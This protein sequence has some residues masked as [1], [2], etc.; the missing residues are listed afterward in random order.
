LAALLTVSA[1]LGLIL[2]K[3]WEPR[4]FDLLDFSE[5][6]PRLIPCETYPDRLRALL[7]YYVQDQGRFNL[8]PYGFIALKWSLF[9]WN[10]SLWYSARFLQML[11]IL[12]A[13]FALLRRL[14]TSALGAAFGASLY[15]STTSAMTA[16]TRLT[17]GEPLALMFMLAATGLACSY[18]ATTRWRATAI[19][20]GLLIAGAVLSKEMVVALAPLPWYIGCSLKP[21]GKLIPLQ[22]SPRNA[23]LTISIGI[24]LVLTLAPIAWVAAHARQEGF[25][26]QY[27]QDTPSLLWMAARWFGFILPAWPGRPLATVFAANVLF[28]VTLVH[29]WRIALSDRDSR[30]SRKR[31]LLLSLALPTIGALAYVPWP[32]ILPFYGFPFQVAESI[33]LAVAVT[34]VVQRFPRAQP[35]IIVICCCFL[36]GFSLQAY[37][38]ARQQFAREEINYQLAVG[39]PDFPAAASGFTGARVVFPESWRGPGPA[40]WRYS[41]AVTRRRVTTRMGNIHCDQL[42]QL[43][44]HGTRSLLISYS[45][46]CGTLKRPDRSYVGYF[47]YLEL[48]TFLLR[49]DSLRVDVAFPD[50]NR[51]Q[52]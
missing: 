36:L 46:E 16:W 22:P 1:A 48:P 12:A 31:L 41:Q 39:L 30:Q 3:P 43:E 24:C 45:N 8:L 6:L 34:A 7:T 25:A 49:K 9:G 18:Q 35:L 26:L 32:L 10:T 4:P 28:F 17:M 21:D 47:H 44:S 52:P 38:A 42:R 51:W 11:L 20:I 29:G 15:L 13:V 23:W 19:G 2:Y 33:L 40:L 37:R 5:F 27:G 50:T 14:D